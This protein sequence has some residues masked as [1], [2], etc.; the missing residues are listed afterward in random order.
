MPVPLA[1]A[2]HP[3]ARAPAPEVARSIARALGPEEIELSPPAWLRPDQAVSFRRV[4]AALRRFGT[5][6]LADPVGSGKTWIALA[7]AQAWGSVA[8]TACIVPASLRQ[9]WRGTIRRV[10]ID[11]ITWSHQLVSRGRLPPGEPGF[12]IIDESHHFRNPGTLRYG[13]FARWVV[14]QPVLLVSATPVV[15]AAS[16]LA[17]QL[18]LGAADDALSEHGL[19]SLR[20]AADDDSR[21]ALGALVVGRDT[22]E[23]VPTIRTEKHATPLDCRSRTL[24]RHIDALRFSRDEG[25]AALLRVGLVRA[26]ASSPA[27]LAGAARRYRA[28]LLQAHDADA[29]GRVAGRAAL[30]SIGGGDG[31]QLVMWALL[32]ASAD[33]WELAL[34]D[35]RPLGTILDTLHT[36]EDIAVGRSFADPRLHLLQELLADGRPTVVFSAWRDTITWLRNALGRPVAWCTGDRAGLSA[37]RTTRGAA[38]AP[39]QR[40]AGPLPHEPRILLASDVAAEGLDL[41]AVSRVVHYDLPWTSMRLEQRVGRARRLGSQHPNVEVVMLEP[42]VELEERIGLNSAI[43]QKRSLARLLV[44]SPPWRWR[45]ALAATASEGRASA[46]VGVVRGT[47]AGVLAG[48]AVQAADG[49]GVRA[50]WVGWRAAGTTVWVTGRE[51]ISARLLEALDARPGEAEEVPTS[52]VGQVVDALAPEAAMLLRR[53]ASSRLGDPFAEP[54]SIALR[55]RVVALAVDARRRR[56]LRRLVPLDAWLAFLARGHTAGEARFIDRLRALGQDRL[57]REL[58]TGVPEVL[59]R[60]RDVNAD[61]RPPA[62]QLT[63]ILVFR[64]GSSG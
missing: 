2:L 28:L 11:A 45:A 24:L 14:G 54:G 6:L 23:G 31:S 50:G 57:A 37:V 20:A 64:R 61:H 63:G 40:I 15:N 3:G 43:E 51:I 5:A 21:T 8:P 19:L 56:D 62:V 29:A 22:A 46:G 38:L 16:D 9:Q 49:G 36:R 53:V 26:L 12:V 27:A 34:E 7:V 33:A 32:P 17:H 18:L 59:R 47:V 13:H 60:F 55:R 25:V 4:L 48:F 35:I 30:R 39:F 1:T 42:S 58:E 10:G 44:E 41:Y 52:E